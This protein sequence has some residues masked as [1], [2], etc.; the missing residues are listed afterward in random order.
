MHL[1]LIAEEHLRE[2]YVYGA[3]DLATGGMLQ[4]NLP[5]RPVQVISS[6]R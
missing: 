3:S 6:Q 4:M 2:S 5:I 1:P